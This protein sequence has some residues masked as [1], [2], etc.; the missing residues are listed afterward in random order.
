MF[1]LHVLG[2]VSLH[3]P[4]GRR[5]SSVLSQP[6]RLALLVLLSLAGSSRIQRDALLGYLW[7]E[8]PGDVA[9]KRLRQALYYLRRSL[10]PDVI[11]GTGSEALCVSQEKVRCDAVVLENAAAERD[12]KEVLARYQGDFMPGF[13][14]DGGPP[15]FDQWLDATRARLRRTAAEAARNLAR[16][17]LEAGNK[18]AAGAAARRAWQLADWGEPAL[19]EL[20]TLLIESDDFSGA[21]AAYAEF[22]ER[23]KEEYDAQ[24]SAE[25]QTLL[26]KLAVAPEGVPNEPQM[27]AS[28]EDEASIPTLSVPFP[29][30][31][32]SRPAP[33]GRQ[34][35]VIA[36]G[37]AALAAVIV[38]LLA[39]ATSRESPPQLNDIWADP[40]LYMEPSR[41]LTDDRRNSVVAE[42]AEAELA[43]RLHRAGLDLIFSA[44]EPGASQN[45]IRLLPA[46]SEGADGLEL[47]VMLLDVGSGAVLDRLVTAQGANTTHI[48]ENLAS[49]M[50]PLIREA[51][52]ELLT[53]KGL[54]ARSVSPAALEA[55]RAAVAETKA[56]I[57]LRGQGA[58]PAAL[59]AFVA[60]DS[61][62]ELATQKSPDWQAPLVKG[63]EVAIEVVWLHLLTPETSTHRAHLAALAGIQKANLAVSGS[64]SPG[65]A[66]SAR[67]RLRHWAALTAANESTRRA[68]S[69][70]A[71]RDLLRATAI[72]AGLPKAW[73]V[74]SALAEERKDYPLAYRRARRAYAADRYLQVP[75]DILARLFTNAIRVGDA[76]GTEQWCGEIMERAPHHWMGTYCELSHLA[77]FGSA[78]IEVRDSLRQR[79]IEQA[80][81]RETPSKNVEARFNLLHAIGLARSGDIQKARY[82]LAQA[83]TASG[84]GAAYEE[85]RQRAHSLLRQ[86]EDSAR[87]RLSG[88]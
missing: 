44:Q 4:D 73:N 26:Q 59:D 66:L 61:L 10:G 27:D 13:F 24:P 57:S 38:P 20:L 32:T 45:G 16:A 2:T 63:A 39:V 22:A 28:V 53:R 37:I 54:D 48:P 84:T 12:W 58:M 23:L 85:L 86:Q 14:L 88:R 64:S 49:Q 5:V 75:Y 60:A 82:F 87:V 35:K 15:A 33:W 52:G 46:V 3:H 30:P 65:Q 50:A 29:P 51:I 80:Q 42:V 67:G 11:S 77:A 81:T 74:L 1:T 34:A 17:E 68:F 71:E 41:N 83:E 47:S 76:E 6:K 36:K 7:P 9:R 18:V 31:S 78:S 43:A 21:R 8:L 62:Y 69:A 79:G 40:H 55:V 25:T 56:G 72:D 19:R 70:S